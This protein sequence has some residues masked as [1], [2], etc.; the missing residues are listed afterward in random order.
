MIIVTEINAMTTSTRTLIEQI[1]IN[2][3][4]LSRLQQE[5]SYL[6]TNKYKI[7]DQY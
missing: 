2:A 7:V 6:K 3:L 5:K 4:L 1:K